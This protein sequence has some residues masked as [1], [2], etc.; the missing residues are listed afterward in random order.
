MF[1]EVTRDI[2]SHRILP[3]SKPQMQQAL[4]R[5]QAA[6]C[7][8]GS[9]VCAHRHGTGRHCAVWEWRDMVLDKQGEQKD[10]HFYSFLL[11]LCAVW[12]LKWELRVLGLT[13][14]SPAR[15]DR[16]LGKE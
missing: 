7:W 12:I 4:T 15:K 8:A 2:C 5:Y 14:R 6:E 10:D 1:L 3:P 9:C 16:G 13:L 11:L